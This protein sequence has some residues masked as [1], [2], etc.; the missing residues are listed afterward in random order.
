MRAIRI[1]K[2]IKIVSIKAPVLKNPMDVL[3]KVKAVGLCGSDVQR[4][5]NIQKNSKA[6]NIILGHEIAG[7][8]VRI[9]GKVKNLRKGDRVAIEPLINCGKC[10]FCKSGNYQLC[11][12]L[13][14]I[15]K[16][17]NGGFAEYVVVPSDKVFR[18]GKKVSYEEGVFLDSLAVCVHALH[19]AE[20]VKDQ[21]VAIVGDGTIGRICALLADYYKAQIVNIFGKHAE[22]R[23]FNPRKIKI[24]N[25]TLSDSLNSLENYFDVVF[26]CVGR[27]QSY[28]LNLAIDLVKPRGKI[29]V[30]GVFP[31]NYLATLNVRKLFIKEAMLLGSNSYGCYRGK[32]E[33]KEASEILN[34]NVLDLKRLIT[35]ALPLSQFEKGIWCFKNKKISKAIKI[36]FIP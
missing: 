15:G 17:L 9:G 30:L 14:S 27:G 23:D 18:L 22:K 28:T 19:I 6:N 10:R 12:N 13:K 1:S 20:G 16:N 7:E 3:I 8:I 29:V 32:K 4:I 34:K 11:S 35:H 24:I 5:E 25:L 21:K 26:E 2:D 31:E 33:I 36:V